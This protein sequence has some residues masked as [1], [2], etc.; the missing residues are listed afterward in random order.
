M[1]IALIMITFMAVLPV[2][3]RIDDQNKKKYGGHGFEYMHGYSSS[4][5]TGY[6][7]YDGEKLYQ[8][9]HEASLQ[10]EDEETMP[11]LDGAEACYP[12]YSAI[13]KAVYRNIDEIEKYYYDLS[14]DYWEKARKEKEYYDYDIF[15]IY[16]T[17]GKVVTF[18]NTSEAYYRLVDRKVDM[19]FAARPSWYHKQYA[20]QHREQILTTPIGKE[21]FVFFVEEDNPISDLSS[22]QIRAIYHGDITNWKQLGGPNQKIIAFQRPENSGSQVMMRWFMGDIELQE[23]KTY[24]YASGMGGVV[25]EVAQYHNEAGAIGYSFRYFLSE[26]HQEEHI[27]ILTI[28]GIE[29][30]LKNIENG[31]YPA[32]VDLVC[33]TLASNE[34]E[35]VKKMME[36]LLSDDGQE[37]I[38]GSGYARL[39]DRNVETTIENEVADIEPAQYIS[40]DEDPWI[41]KIYDYDKEEGDDVFELYNSEHFYKG[42]FTTYDDDS[43]VAKNLG[44]YSADTFDNRLFIYFD[45]DS[46]EDSYVTNYAEFS[47]LDEAPEFPLYGTILTRVRKP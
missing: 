40:D 44:K 9:D 12:L 29:P 27:K 5:F 24:E 14:N 20:T 22:E 3:S 23:P 33:A 21:A 34:K 31:T 6:Q 28:D 8:L 4:D 11:I 36:F 35:N 41:L 16:E 43:D 32:T 45:H 39:K 19:V 38:E 7:V 26:F 37:L 1:L 46:A 25:K 47:D 15:E 2:K 13:A 18:T 17:N 42:Y 30:S 10:I